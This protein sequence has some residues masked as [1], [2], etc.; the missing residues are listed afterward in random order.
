MRRIQI[1]VSR[2]I[3]ARQFEP[4]TVDVTET[5]DVQDEEEVSEAR[6]NL[7]KDVTRSV[8]K[9]IDNEKLKVA[10]EKQEHKK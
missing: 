8:K 9:Y 3:Q 5:I 2:T 7:Y 10:Q 4:V 1:R 6:L